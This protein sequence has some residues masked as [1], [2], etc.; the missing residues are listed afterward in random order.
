MGFTAP[1]DI[2]HPA[3]LHFLDG[4]DQVSLELEEHC[5]LYKL[6]F[7]QDAMTCIPGIVSHQLR[8]LT[9]AEK[10]HLRLGHAN[11]DKL[12][13]LSKCAICFNSPIASAQHEYPC[14]T[15][16]EAKARQQ[17]YPPLYDHERKGVWKMDTLDMGEDTTTPAGHCYITAVTILDTC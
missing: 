9:T 14:H 12:A 6:P 8:V 7:C 17:N 16:C 3:T 11:W 15:C 4:S 2:T 1:A 10:W 5:G 13:K